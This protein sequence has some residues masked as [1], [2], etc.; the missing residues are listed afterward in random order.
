MNTQ[1]FIIDGKEVGVE[2][3]LDGSIIKA[4][5]KDDKWTI[6]PV[7]TFEDGKKGV[8]EYCDGCEVEELKDLK[9][10]EIL[11][12]EGYQK[13]W[14]IVEELYFQVS[15]FKPKKCRCD[16][17]CKDWTTF[18]VFL[19]FDL[20]KKYGQPLEIWIKNSVLLNWVVKQFNYKID[21][22]TDTK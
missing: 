18:G 12:I 6:G 21:K 19:A 16:K 3:I 11:K 9:N 7:I 1:K 13:M 20:I 14:M 4:Y 22:K 10:I 5:K 15:S 2:G 8:Q 17:S